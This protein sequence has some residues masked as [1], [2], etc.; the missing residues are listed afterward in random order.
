MDDKHWKACL[1]CCR[2]LLG[3]GS[4]DPFL[5]RSWCAFTTFSSLKNGVHYWSCGFPDEAEYLET[6]T[7]D[8]GLWRQAFDYQD[9]AHLIVPASFYWEGFH[10]GS[11]RVGTKTQNLALLSENLST[12]GIEHRRTDLVLELKLY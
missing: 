6:H 8:G 5:S 3:E 12:L 7:L 4:W 9:L 1:Q 10:E 2:Q 11:F